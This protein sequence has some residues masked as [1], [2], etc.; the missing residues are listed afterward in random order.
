[1]ESATRPPSGRRSVQALLAMARSKVTT[2]VVFV[3]AVVSVVGSSWLWSIE[4][5]DAETA[6][7][8]RTQVVVDST[9]KALSDANLRLVSVAG[10]YQASTE[11]TEMEFRR[12]VKKLGLSP[13][14]DAIGVMPLVVG[15]NRDVFEAEM[16]TLH[17]GFAL[18]D[19]DEAGTRVPADQRRIHLPLQWYEPVDSFDHIEGFDSLSDPDRAEALERARLTRNTSISPFIRLVSEQEGDGFVM[20]WP[21]TDAETEA[22][23]GFATAAMDLGN[24]MEGA[25]SDAFEPIL[26]WEV[27][28]VTTDVE[29]EASEVP[30]LSRIEIG[31]RI[32][33]LRITPDSRTD[34]IP[35]V[36]SSIIVLATGLVATAFV[37]GTLE[38]RR[39]HRSAREQLEN[40]RELTQAK[41]QFLASVGHELR[42]PLTSV[43][44]FAELLREDTGALTEEER[45]VM[46]TSVAEE[47][48][49]LAAIVDD[50]LVAARSELDLLVVTEVP[51]SARA[52]IAQVL[53]M[54]GREAGERIAVLGEPGNAYQALG[55]PARVR[56]IMRNMITNACR[57]GGDIVEIRLRS[58]EKQV[59]VQVADN[60]DGVP[61]EAREQI[62]VP[63]H[64]AHS[65][66]SQP[67]AL[68]IGLSVA[69]QL[70]RLMNGDLVY[71]RQGGWTIFELSLPR[72]TVP[73]NET[74]A[75][76][77]IEAPRVTVS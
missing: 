40:L 74:I 8:T 71:R 35:S 73:V 43:L 64:R 31:G 65:S 13:G 50:L 22:L 37:A 16:R 36:R 58:N 59:T 38:N 15:R 68:G 11:V 48:T 32:W 30:G 49:D 41:D 18:F 55:D 52:Q 1:M 7:V 54:S 57:Y 27:T 77:S 53:E 46:I 34:M 76:V 17:P 29:R 6:L 28:D 10:L 12:F 45:V 39:K 25:V 63:Y 42:T 26:D 66:A 5:S 51:V 44:G 21:I 3:G 33:E 61:Q 9:T 56:Q 4:R 62:F 70:A 67:A 60:G 69:R 2:I 72:M 20:Y 75:P 24:L 47:A 14:M 19:V 23:I